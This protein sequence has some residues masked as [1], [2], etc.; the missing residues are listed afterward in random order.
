MLCTMRDADVRNL[1]S[2]SHEEADTRLFLH[3]AD[4]VCRK[5]C[6]RTVD[7]DVVVLAIAV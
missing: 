1:A 5:L 7:T 2:C 6:L 3:A 4:A